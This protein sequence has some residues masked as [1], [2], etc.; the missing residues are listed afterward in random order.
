MYEVSRST[1]SLQPGSSVLTTFPCKSVSFLL[2]DFLFVQ[3]VHLFHIT[4]T[5]ATTTAAAAAV[6]VSHLCTQIFP[7]YK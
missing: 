5:T 2:T 6:N 7:L 1:K 4:T 3:V